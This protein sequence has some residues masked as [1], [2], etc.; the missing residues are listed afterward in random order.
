[1]AQVSLEVLEFP[2]LWEPRV[3]SVS[4]VSQDLLALLE[5]REPLAVLELQ[6]QLEFKVLL[7]LLVQQALLDLL[8]LLE[9]QVLSV[10]LERLVP[11][12]RQV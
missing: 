6:E 10:L 2:A 4:L 8:E 1:M 11:K 7:E 9:Y 3:T 12:V 5:Q